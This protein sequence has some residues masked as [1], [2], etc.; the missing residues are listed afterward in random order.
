MRTILIALTFAILVTAGMLG[1]L[2]LVDKER[3]TG[4]DRYTAYLNARPTQP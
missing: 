4:T 3:A 1:A 2:V